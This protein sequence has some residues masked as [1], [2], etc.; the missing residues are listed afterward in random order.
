MNIVSATHPVFVI[1]FVSFVATAPQTGYRC[2]TERQGL[3]QT[4]SA[5]SF[6]VHLTDPRLSLQ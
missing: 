4:L 1:N 5:Y 3:T 6:V 2:V